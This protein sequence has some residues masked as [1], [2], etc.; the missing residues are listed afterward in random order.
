MYRRE[1]YRSSS[2]RKY[3]NFKPRYGGQ[4]RNFSRSAAS[5]QRDTVSVVVKQTY[6]A[7]IDIKNGG[8]RFGFNPFQNLM[9]SS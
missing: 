7:K 5:G 4:S 6:G 9:L 3:S 8:I 2:T 1:P